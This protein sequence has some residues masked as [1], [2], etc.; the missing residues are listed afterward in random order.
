MS[1]FLITFREFQDSHRT[2]ESEET[3]LAPNLA[4]ELLGAEGN[5]SEEA[6]TGMFLFDKT[7]ARNITPRII[8]ADKYIQTTQEHAKK[9]AT[10][11]FENPVEIE[12]YIRRS[13]HFQKGQNISINNQK[14]KSEK[15]NQANLKPAIHNSKENLSSLSIA[16]KKKPKSSQDTQTFA[17]SQ[18]DAETETL[19]ATVSKS[20]ETTK[21]C[22]QEAE[23]QTFLKSLEADTQYESSS[24]DQSLSTHF[25]SL[26]TVNSTMDANVSCIQIIRNR[27]L[28]LTIANIESLS[29]LY[30]P[31]KSFQPSLSPSTSDY[32]QQVNTRPYR[33]LVEKEIQTNK[34]NIPSV[35]NSP[36][37]RLFKEDR[38]CL[39]AAVQTEI[40]SVQDVVLDTSPSSTSPSPSAPVPPVIKK[41]PPALQIDQ[42]NALHDINLNSLLT[43]D[44]EE[45][46]EGS[47][48]FMS[49]SVDEERLPPAMPLET[50]NTRAK[51]TIQ[52]LKRDPLKDFFDLV[53]FICA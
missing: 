45:L 32:K 53:S 27:E 30:E 12:I 41:R 46:S 47:G 13:L 39:C 31:S 8:T 3:E 50:P 29:I 52:M 36:V 19:I 35:N 34:I 14:Q 6:D 1:L 20:T 2:V 42:I 23:I 4:N 48:S 49:A 38:D 51:R 10:L 16:A 9:Q 18:A 7:S 25:P 24:K 17:Q 44:E 40:N 26:F 43:H 15:A 33:I 22:L 21:L 28:D 5:E 37:N 11:K